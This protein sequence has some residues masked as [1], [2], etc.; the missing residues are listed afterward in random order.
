MRRG[1]LDLT[2]LGFA[3]PAI[4]SLRNVASLWDNRV[5]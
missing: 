2:T 3:L 4:V 1:F 5:I